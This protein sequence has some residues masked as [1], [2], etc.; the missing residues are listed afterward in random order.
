LGGHEPLEGHGG[1]AWTIRVAVVVLLAAAALLAVLSEV[2]VGA[3]VPFIERFGLSTF[4][5]GVVLIPTIGNLAEHLVAVQL[6][7]EN[8]MDDAGAVACAPSRRGAGFVARAL[9]LR[10]LVV[11]QPMNLVFE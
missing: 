2:L 10:A 4:F 7:W 11:T 6:A 9:A 8:K 5:V 1:P 3:I